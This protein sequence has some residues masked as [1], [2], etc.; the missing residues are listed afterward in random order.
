VPKG[1]RINEE[2]VELGGWVVV[3]EV[4]PIPL[5]DPLTTPQPAL[6]PSQR[7]PEIHSH[8]VEIL[9]A[10]GIQI[11]PRI[12]GDIGREGRALLLLYLHKPIMIPPS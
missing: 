12:D 3:G 5:A 1:F 4:S 7:Q 9:Y 11:R 10:K 6:V 2:L 8:I